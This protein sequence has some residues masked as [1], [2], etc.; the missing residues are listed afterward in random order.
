MENLVILF[1]NFWKQKKI[2]ITG[3]TG[4]KGSWLSHILYTL[5]AE[6]YGISLKPLKNSHYTISKTNKLF[7]K[8]FF[9]NIKSKE[10]KYI[11][12]K[13]KPEIII[14]LASQPIVSKSIENPK[15]T[16]STNILGLYNLME[17]F[18]DLDSVK[19]FLNVTTDKVY[20]PKE[21]KDYYFRENDKL[22]GHDPYSSSKACAELIT[23]STYLTYFKKKKIYFATARSGNVIGGGDFAVNR[24]I[25]D[26]FKS[27]KK[28][29][30]I[31][32]RNPNHIRPWQHVLEP[33]Y[34]YLLLI[35]RISDKKLDNFSSWNFGP[36]KSDHI[37]VKDVVNYLSNI[38]KFEKI[39]I[40]K[41][42]FLENIDLRLDSSKSKKILKWKSVLDI[43]KGL[44]FTADWYLEFFKNG[45]I[46]TFHQ[47]IDYYERLSLINK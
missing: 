45:E 4:F 17:V 32:I 19:F 25:P 39:L 47:I 12:K 3:H 5:N 9:L 11:I 16:F 29:Q 33:L 22:G 18:K 31:I 27:Y 41:S 1:E 40:N 38:T 28:N 30:N 42:D 6:L 10:L 35:F 26:F 8:E 21:K 14:H 37:N 44:D 34:G 43:K 15:H 24:L 7:K 36:K 20:L 2:L 13:I 46:K 23:L